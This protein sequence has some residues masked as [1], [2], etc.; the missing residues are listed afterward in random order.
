MR[1]VC[2][3]EA[4]IWDIHGRLHAGFVIRYNGNIIWRRNHEY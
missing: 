4:P 1:I 2:V 3:P